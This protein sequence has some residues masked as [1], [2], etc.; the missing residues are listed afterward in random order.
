M[1]YRYALYEKK[2]RIAYV[3]LNRPEVMNALHIHCHREL[4]EIWCDFRDDP[5][6]W[7]AI[8]TGAGEKAFC[9]GNDLKYTAEHSGEPA[10][11][12]PPG[13][14]GGITN[15]FECWKP[16]IAAVNGYALG[17]GFEIDCG[18][19]AF[20]VQL[21]RFAKGAVRFPIPS[22][23]EVRPA[24]LRC[25]DVANF[26]ID[27]RIERTQELDHLVVTVVDTGF[28]C[29]FEGGREVPGREVFAR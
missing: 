1:A 18:F 2:D 13:G 7:V 16:I 28:S 9:A 26:R 19:D 3:T 8:V 5:E 24:D 15:R 29:C 22:E 25:R 6:L 27:V 14:F 10:P 4:A 17:G 21:H 11:P 23:V 12:Q 20:G